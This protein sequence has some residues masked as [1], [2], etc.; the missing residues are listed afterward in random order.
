MKNTSEN[1]ATEGGGNPRYRKR[2]CPRTSQGNSPVYFSIH[3]ESTLYFSAVVGKNPPQGLLYIEA[4]DMG[5]SGDNDRV[6]MRHISRIPSEWLVEEENLLIDQDEDTP[7]LSC[8]SNTTTSSSQMNGGDLS[9]QSL[10]KKQKRK[11]KRAAQKA[12]RRKAA[13]E[14]SCSSTTE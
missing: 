10:S 12:K 11:L 13:E 9:P 8:A 2:H 3:P 6:M 1:G 14:H 4:V 7:S 5:L